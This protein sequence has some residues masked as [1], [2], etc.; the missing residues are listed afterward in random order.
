MLY[1]TIS[2]SFISLITIIL[3]HYIYS[4]LL[5]NLTTPKIK[6]PIYFKS[7]EVK[8]N[9]NSLPT[10]GINEVNSSI[11]NNE[12]QNMQNEL[13]NFLNELKIKSKES[14]N[15][16]NNDYLI[17]NIPNNYLPST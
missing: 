11:D 6:D 17:P 5:D 13:Q 7:K 1:W 16:N 12:K 2:W 8:S 9:E 10:G 4:F 15:S 3:I 14:Q